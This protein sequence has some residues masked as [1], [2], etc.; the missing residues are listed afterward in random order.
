MNSALTYGELAALLN[1]LGFQSISS[2]G[3]QQVFQNPT[4]DALI[5]L[6]PSSPTEPVR[7]HHLATIRKLVVERGIADSEILD[8]LLEDHPLAKA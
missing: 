7:P 6:P 8:R 1:Q 5:A 4:F 2:S 3:P